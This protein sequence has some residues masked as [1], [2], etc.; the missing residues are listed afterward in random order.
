MR[1]PRHS[2][3]LK[4]TEGG[5][6]YDPKSGVRINPI[7]VQALLEFLLYCG[8]CGYPVSSC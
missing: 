3:P 5:H 6:L 4:P 1:V 8:L 7:F 2:P